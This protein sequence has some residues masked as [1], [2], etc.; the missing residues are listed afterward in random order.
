MSKLELVRHLYEYND[1]ANGKLLAAARGV[2]A[3]ELAAGRAVSWGNCLTGF[4]HIAAAQV[5]WL[6]RWQTGA[7]EVSTTDLQD[8]LVSLDEVHDALKR[9]HA[10]LRD[11]VGALTDER[12]DSPLPYRDSTGRTAD[13]PLWQLMTHVANHGSYHRGELAAALTGL[14]HS[15]GDLDFLFWEVGLR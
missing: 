11:F 15:P 8:G 12:L 6:E 13:R 14:G 4:G 2:P 1:W 5:N 7:N 10:S 3:A 9:S